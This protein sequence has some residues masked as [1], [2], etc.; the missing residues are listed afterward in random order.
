MKIIFLDFDGVISTNRAY[1]ANMADSVLHRDEK[2]IDPIACTMLRRLC[3]QYEYT[4]VVTSTWRKFGKP[5]IQSVLTQH[6]LWEYVHEDWKTVEIWDKGSR[7]SR[8]LEI[9]EWL[10]RNKCD[11]YLILD[12]DCFNWTEH[13]FTR[14]IKTDTLNGFST[15]NYEAVVNANS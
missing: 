11:H 14:W 10:S 15:Q 8:P 13:Q 1:L 5:R 2:W 12:D 9:E 7:N 3:K 4:L 6:N